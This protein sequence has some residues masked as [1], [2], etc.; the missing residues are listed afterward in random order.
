MT[1]DIGRWLGKVGF[2]EYADLF[3]ANEIELATLPHLSEDDL[4][5]LGLPMGPRK[6]LLAAIAAFGPAELEKPE[7][8]PAS[9]EAERRQLTIMFVDLVGS[10]ALATRLDLE[11]LRDVT[12]R[13]QNLVA[14]EI[15]RYEGHVAR[16]MGDGV[17]I[18]FGFP[19][20]HEDDA[21]RAV[22]AALAITGSLGRESVASEPLEFLPLTSLHTQAR[23]Q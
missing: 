5:E 9:A 7:A 20:A 21:E 1:D 17:L 15:A 22:R 8:P 6:K 2:A 18:Y 23:V 4:K 11:K 13:Y 12:C 19:A 10:T 3:A 14:G 16:F